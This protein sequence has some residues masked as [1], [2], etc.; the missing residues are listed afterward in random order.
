[1]VAA[2]LLVVSGCAG[3]SGGE[4]DAGRLAPS[5]KA[6]IDQ[7]LQAK[8]ISDWDRAS[9]E[10]ASK[11]GRIEQ[12][13]Y[14]EGMNLFDQCMKSAGFEFTRTELL[15]GVIEFQPPRG[16]LSEDEVSA[17]MKAQSTCSSST[18]FYTQDLF[19]MQ[20]ANPDLLSDF[21]Q[22]AVNC[23]K[24]AGIVGDDF[25]KEEFEKVSGPRDSS[26]DGYPFDVMDP[27]AQTCLYSLGYAI[28]VAPQ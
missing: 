6:L 15:N 12:A 14:A 5:L 1:M 28:K 16:K 2:T 27:K 11:A 17:M 10:K 21:S 26:E 20:Q 13:D 24:K 8:D 4:A 18:N 22:A 19:R 25:T 23:L 9:L 7:N 3:S